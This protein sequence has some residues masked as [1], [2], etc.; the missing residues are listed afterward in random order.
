M[1]VAVLGAGM[2]G[3]AAGHRLVAEGHEVDVYERWPG[4]GGQAAIMDAGDGVQIERYYHHLFTSD[5]EIHDL[6][7]EIGL[8]DELA[9]WKSDMGMWSHGK[10]WPFT[11]PMDL[12]RYKPLSPI[13]RIR[14]GIAAVLLQRKPDDVRPYEGQTIKQ[15]VEKN[16]GKQVWVEIWHP[17]LRGKFGEK[18]DQISMSWLF[19]KLRNRRQTSGE[20]A[21]QE[22]LVYPRNSFEAI[23]QRLQQK[24]EENGR[25]L[26]DRPAARISR[27]DDGGFL[28]H[29]AAPDSFRKGHDPREFESGGEPERYDAVLATLP[30]D[31]FEQVLDPSLRAEVTPDYFDKANSIE[32]YAALCMVLELDRKFHDYYWTN[33]CDEDMKFIGLIEHTQPDGAR[34]LRRPP[35]PLRGQLPAARPRVPRQ[36]PR[37]DA[38]HLRAGAE[39]GE[40]RV[41]PRLDQ[42]Q[43]A[44]QGAG[45]AADRAAQLSGA[46]AAVLDRRPG[47]VHG[48]HDAGLPRRPGHEL[49]RARGR[50]GREGAARR[51]GQ[52]PVA[53]RG[54]RVGS[55][56]A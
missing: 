23:F 29:P 6:C 28:V 10:L 17:L 27:T 33:V 20:E 31:I 55:R 38:R 53:G 30:T 43:L 1:K 46:D 26:I 12:L 41:Q 51:A 5:K 22:L 34:A 44:L 16:M 24:I 32:Y 36:G 35:L 15:W 48:Q 49:R 14:M 42:G 25:V 11:S 18:A 13:S 50:R 47:P 54:K 19:A 56:I 4:L 7:A 2:A 9:K 39:E 37:S 3:L 21:K 8:P 52:A 40:P 45:R